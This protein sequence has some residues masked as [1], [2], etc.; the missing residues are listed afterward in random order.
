M[1]NIWLTREWVINDIGLPREIRS[2]E[3]MWLT[4]KQ[5]GIKDKGLPWEM[6]MYE[7]YVVN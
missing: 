6:K 7:K 2:Y 3:N 4:R 1:E 5:G